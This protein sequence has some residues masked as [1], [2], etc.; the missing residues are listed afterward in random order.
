[1]DFHVTGYEKTVTVYSIKASDSNVPADNLASQRFVRNRVSMYDKKGCLYTDTVAVTESLLPV[2]S[3]G[4]DTS[5]LLSDSLRLHAPATYTTYHWHD[6]T[7]EAEYLV[8]ATGGKPGKQTCWLEVTDSL[9]CSFTDT[10]AITFFA[11]STSAYN[12]IKLHTWPNPVTEVL[13]WSIETGSNSRLVLEITDGYGRVLTS[14]D[15]GS[16]TSGQAMQ[17]DVSRFPQGS[18]IIKVNT[19]TGETIKTQSFVKQ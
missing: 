19:A 2:F 6:G 14:K 3:L 8:T 12:N 9:G 16:Y 17:V 18:Y 7:Y 5:L 4:M 13:N 15:I 11:S 1:M 10:I